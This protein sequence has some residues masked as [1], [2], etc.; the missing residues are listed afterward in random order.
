MLRPRVP[1]SVSGLVRLRHSSFGACATAQGIHLRLL[2]DLLLVRLSQLVPP[3]NRRT[4]S[5]ITLKLQHVRQRH[6]P[7]PRR[8]HLPAARGLGQERYLLSRQSHKHRALQ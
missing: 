4:A 6:L 2:K 3:N 7:R 5:D 8:H 1:L